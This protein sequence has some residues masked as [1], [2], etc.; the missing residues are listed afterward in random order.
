MN[1][2]IIYAESVLDATNEMKITKN[3]DTNKS[4][5]VVFSSLLTSVLKTKTIIQ[6]SNFKTSMSEVRYKS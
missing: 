1:G 5:D 3:I 4:E 6:F 2:S